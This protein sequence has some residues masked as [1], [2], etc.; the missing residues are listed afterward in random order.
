MFYADAKSEISGTALTFVSL[1]F[2]GYF[3]KITK[4]TP[5]FAAFVAVLLYERFG[6][7]FLSAD[8]YDSAFGVFVDGSL[9][10][11]KTVLIIC[12]IAVV[13]LSI[14][15]AIRNSVKNR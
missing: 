1:A 15:R 10:T 4:K 5:F 12:T 2:V 11:L 6:E 14:V 8:Y 3:C 13:V 9:P 7:W